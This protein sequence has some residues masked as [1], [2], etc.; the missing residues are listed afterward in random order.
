MMPPT[1]SSAQ[2]RSHIESPVAFAVATG[3]FYFQ[4]RRGVCNDVRTILTRSANY[5]TISTESL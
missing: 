4:V 1:L 2:P 5:Y 3:P